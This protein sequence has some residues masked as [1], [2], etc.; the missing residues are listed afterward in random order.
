M[1]NSTK[2]LIGLL[3][4]GSVGLVIFLFVQFSSNP[5]K[6]VSVGSK[7]ASADCSTGQEDCLP[8]INYVDTTG[9]AYT[10]ESLKGKIL[11][12]NFWATWCPPCKTEIPDLSRI[13]DKYRDKGVVLLGVTTED[14][15]SSALVNFAS[16]HEL[17]YPIVRG[18][19]EMELAYGSPR[20]LPTTFIFD[21]KGRLVYGKAG[22]LTER[23]LTELIEPLLK[24]S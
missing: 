20:N 22:G 12:V 4:A 8:A 14:I 6:P 2:A 3:L 23:K 21:R 24:D 9:V 17:S 15:S 19:Q 5:S 10:P 18:T 16:D 7:S 11:I 1:T 13:W